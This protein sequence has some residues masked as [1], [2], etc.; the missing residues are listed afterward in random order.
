MKYIV[1]RQTYK[2]GQQKDVPI[3]FPEHLVHADVERVIRAILQID[4]RLST[5]ECVSGG[6]LSSMD[7][8]VSTTGKS[9]SLNVVSRK[10][11]DDRLIQFYDYQ[12]GVVL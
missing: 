2:S 1:I 4:N 7:L 3:I 11:A 9:E 6:F 5:F 8:N 12:H 10:E